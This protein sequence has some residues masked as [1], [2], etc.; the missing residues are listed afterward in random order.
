MGSLNRVTILGT[1]GRDPEISTTQG[2]MSIAKFSVA[3]D[4][5]RKDA[6]G[7]WASIAQW[8]D[9]VLFD[10]K[11]DVAA[12]YVR[13]GSQVLIEG[14]LRTNSWNDKETGQKRYRTEIVGSNLVL[15]GK[16]QQ[17]EESQEQ[18]QAPAQEIDEDSVPF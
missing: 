12:D 6:E 10:K 4:D 8:H 15:V 9:V 14:S 2:G 18:T 16:R 11:A 5:R 3:T 13:K 1:V 17:A 7:N